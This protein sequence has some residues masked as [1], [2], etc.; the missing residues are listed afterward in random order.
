MS[1]I[2]LILLCIY[3]YDE[4]GTFLTFSTS[5]GKGVQGHLHIL[6]DMFHPS[7]SLLGI[8]KKTQKKEVTRYIA[9]GIDR[10]MVK[11]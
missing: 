9:I 5:Q 10:Y 1:Y 2:G 11:I 3:T 8:I 4:L 7:G 6:I